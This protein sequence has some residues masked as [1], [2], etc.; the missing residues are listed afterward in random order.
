[1][2]VALF[3]KSVLLRSSVILSAVITIAMGGSYLFSV[4]QMDMVSNGV[5]IE[6]HAVAR[7]GP[8]TSYEVF[9]EQSLPE[10]TEF[11]IIEVQGDWWKVRL[12]N[13]DEVWINASR[14]D[15]I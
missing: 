4:Y 9:Y 13:N 11:E 2:I 12:V 14:A 1:M 8:G 5:I 3:F 7:K 10:G 6:S 15:I